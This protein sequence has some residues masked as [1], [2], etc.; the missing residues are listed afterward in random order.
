MAK[1][2]RL[3][4]NKAFLILNTFVIYSLATVF[5]KFASQ[6][7]FLS[8][9]YVCFCGCI[10]VALG[11][12]AILWQKILGFMDLNKAFLCKSITILF[13]L[14]FSYLFFNEEIT[15]KN[16]IGASFIIAGLAVLAWKR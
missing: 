16:L 4:F 14:A 5:G 2:N 9:P 3:K 8:L 1:T 12:Y 11:L 15:P 7:T 13:V 10:V 6:H